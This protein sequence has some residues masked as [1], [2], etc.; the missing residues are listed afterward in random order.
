VTSGIQGL[1]VDA[2]GTV[3]GGNAVVGGTITCSAPE[4]WTMTVNVAQKSTGARAKGK[5]AGAC[6]GTLE[7]WSVKAGHGGG[8]AFAP[9]NAKV[10]AAAGLLLAGELRDTRQAQALVSLA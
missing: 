4:R 7:A 8:P 9:G 6:T 1:T 2:D 3:A 5:D 10:V